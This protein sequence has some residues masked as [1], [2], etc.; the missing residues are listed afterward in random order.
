MSTIKKN[1]S[2]ETSAFT[3]LKRLIQGD[4]D[5]VNELILSHAHSQVTDLIPL[6]TEYITSSGGK[7]IRPIL[8]LACAKMFSASGNNHILLATA[9]EFIHTA[10]LLHDDVIDE[11]VTRR[12]I[13]TAN[14]LWGSKA[15]IL[16]GDY[17]FSQAFKLMVKTSS[18]NALD[19][20]SEASAVISEG[21]VWQL[22]N[23][24][25]LSLAEEDYFNLIK[26]KTAALFAAACECGAISANASTE[27]AKLLAEYGSHLGVVFQI[28]DDVLD[29]TT[30]DENFGKKAGGDFREGKV[31][32]PLIIAMKQA[33]GEDK[34]LL[35]QTI[36]NNRTEEGFS[37]V[38]EILN[39]Y[40]A[41]KKSLDIANLY[42]ENGLKVLD[43]LPAHSV[44]PILKELLKQSLNRSF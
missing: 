2:N 15:S 30:S 32:L 7:R 43:T 27:H 12:G 31:T 6:I 13:A 34:S 25:N 23:I 40:D 38:V 39:K 33:N 26:S 5:Q 16:V 29:Y 35:T 44:I 20:L 3:N 11:S 41:F 36:Q 10:T 17:L 37:L 8:T 24:S 19:V 1:S 22:S 21:E 9:V 42:V 28:V 14:Q 18:L 4:L